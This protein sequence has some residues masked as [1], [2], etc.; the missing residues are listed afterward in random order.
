MRK[1]FEY[2]KE[3]PVSLDIVTMLLRVQQLLPNLKK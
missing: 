2:K 1:N 3:F